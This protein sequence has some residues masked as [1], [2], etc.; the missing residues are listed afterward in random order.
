MRDLDPVLEELTGNKLE[1][2]GPLDGF[3]KEIRLSINAKLARSRMTGL[4]APITLFM[5]FQIFKHI[6][7]LVQGYRGSA[8]TTKNGERI[9]LTFQRLDTAEKFGL[10]RDLKERIFSRSGTSRKSP[11]MVACFKVI[12]AGQLL[13]LHKLRRCKWFIQQ[14]NKG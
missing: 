3:L 1:L 5:P 6:W 2:V 10:S 14:N 7:V 13:L 8:D 9:T 12:A 4:M 11:R